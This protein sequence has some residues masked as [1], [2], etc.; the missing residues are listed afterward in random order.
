MQRAA[1][2]APGAV[3]LDEEEQV[4]DAVAPVLSVVALDLSWLGEDRLAHLADEPPRAL[5][6]ADRRPLRIRRF[7][8]EIEHALHAG[9]VI[10]IGLRNA[11]HVLA[12][13]LQD[14]YGHAPAHGSRERLACSVSRTNSPA[15]SLESNAPALRAGSNRPSP[16]AG[17]T[18][19]LAARPR[20]RLLAERRLGVAKHETALGPAFI[21]ASLIEAGTSS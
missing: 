17:L 19:E 4:G 14:V 10:R 15:N 16:P 20:T 11:P 18:R 12:P 6:E 5:I 3:H 13:R 7:G 1:R 21:R 8:I 9:D 2:C